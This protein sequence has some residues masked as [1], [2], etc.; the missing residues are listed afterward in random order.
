MPLKKLIAGLIA[1]TL[2]GCTS[3]VQNDDDSGSD[4]AA[5]VI[6]W[7]DCGGLIGDHACNFTFVDQHGNPWTLYDHIGKVILIDFSAEWCGYCQVSAQIVERTQQDFDPT[8]KEFVWVT[9]LVEDSTGNPPDLAT[10]QAWTN[11][12]GIES[13]PVL[14]ADRTIIDVT[15]EAGYPVE[16][17][18]MFLIV[19]RD[20]TIENGLRGWSEQLILQMIA[21]AIAKQ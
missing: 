9:L 18:P 13:S 15:G 1:F 14:A 12:F 8:G 2:F 10:V 11:Y 7:E 17:W 16:S 19:N 21:D 20:M 3:P 6:D 5:A 4:T